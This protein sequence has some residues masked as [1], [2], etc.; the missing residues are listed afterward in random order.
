MMGCPK[1]PNDPRVII[2]MVL[3]SSILKV[4]TSSLR[5]VLFD[6]GEELLLV[7][8]LGVEAVENV[9]VQILEV[10]Q[11]LHLRGTRLEWSLMQ[12]WNLSI[13]CN[14]SYS[15]TMDPV[16]SGSGCA[17]GCARPSTRNRTK[18]PPAEKAPYE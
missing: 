17:R 12:I 3:K 7:D 2:Q 6:K 13:H 16:T 11:S 14:A 10:G 8:G 5:V 4:L 18:S 15:N 1:G 9:L